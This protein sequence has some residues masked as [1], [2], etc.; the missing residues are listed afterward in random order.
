MA[1]SL[2][3]ID[4]SILD[5]EIE[6]LKTE[7]QKKTAVR[8]YIQSLAKSSPATTGP[9]TTTVTAVP[10]NNAPVKKAA[11]ANAPAKKTAPVKTATTPVPVK[12]AS[13]K[14]SSSN[15]L[16]LTGFILDYLKKN[17][18][19]ESKP[20]IDAFMIASGNKS[21]GAKANV[22]NTLSR[23]RKEGK[24]KVQDGKGTGYLWSLK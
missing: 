4:I 2:I 21:N 11:A 15:P 8:D 17:P 14:S 12:A 23:L 9:A 16:G 1:Q 22:A 18:K 19:S 13:Q 10:K 20:I 6:A 3:Q 5:K 24:L 7:L